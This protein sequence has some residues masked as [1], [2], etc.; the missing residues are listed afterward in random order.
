M[1]FR[2]VWIASAVSGPPRRLTHMARDFPNPGGR[3]D[4]SDPIAALARSLGARQQGGVSQLVWA[5]H[6]RSI[7]FTYRGDLFSVPAEG[8]AVARLT[9]TG[10]GKSEI[11]YSPEGRFIS[12]LQDG[13]LWLWDR[14]HAEPMRVTRLG[15]PPLGSVPGGTYYRP[16]VELGTY[17]WGGGGPAY[18]WSPDGRLVAAQYVDRRGM[19]KVPF[20]H[21]LGEETSV[22][23]L[24]RGYPGDYDEIR[25]LSIYSVPEGRL[26]FVDLPDRNYR[27]FAGLQWS[28]DGKTLLVDQLSEDSQDRWLYLV[29]PRDLSFRELWHDRRETRV[30]TDA[31][32]SQWGSDGRSVVFVGDLDDR[33]RLYVLPLGGGVPKPLTP[34]AY[35]VQGM[36]GETFTVSRATGEIF[37]VSNAKNPYERH[38]YRMPEAG[39]APSPVTSLPGVHEPTLSPD[40]ARLALIRSDDVTPAE[41]Y[42]V[43]ARG[44]PERRVTHSPPGDFQKIAWARPRYVTFKSRADAT[45]LHGRILEPP[46]L[47]GTKK[48]PVILGPAYSNTVRN[49]WAGA[50]GTLQQYLAL[51]GGYIGFQV[52]VRGSTGY[53]R[54]FREQFLMDVGGRDL[55]D[56]ESAVEYLETLPYVD[57]ERIGIWGSSYGGTLTVYSLFRKPGLFKA[58]VAGAPAVDARFFGTDDVSITRLPHTDP[59][60]YRRMSGIFEGEKLED[61]LLIIHGMQDDVVPFKTSVVLAERLMLLGKKFDFAFAPAATHG[62]AQREHYAQYLYWRLVDHFDRYLGRGPR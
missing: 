24:R 41:L 33:Y 55:E 44:G 9:H 29:D 6:G 57:P 8:G 42:L 61:H 51:Q 16:E 18:A 30:Y 60:A 15:V 54:D 50:R 27:R 7:L 21:F 46:H 12:F 1:P 32:L 13:D 39:G 17:V 43:D 37:F 14:A 62:W 48:Y 19:R 47:D 56:L 38:V 52:D 5:A 4:E 3:D 11:A 31:D 22:N 25:G 58:G 10:G 40:G 23:W 26:R 59:E 53:G 49:R 28:P 36:G 35:D 45:T 34:A 20:P 2:D